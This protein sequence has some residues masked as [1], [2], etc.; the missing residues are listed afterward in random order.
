[1]INLHNLAARIRDDHPGIA[2]PGELSALVLAEIDPRDYADALSITLRSYVRHVMTEPRRRSV[3]QPVRERETA[4]QRPPGWSA[5]SQGIRDGWRAHLND[6]YSVAGTWKFLRDLTR[7]DL[8]TVA[9][10]RYD[11]ARANAYEA[12][13]AERLAALME[14]HGAATVA[15]LPDET[16][17]RVLDY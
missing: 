15:D 7:E 14:R 4:P 10:E 1:M 11:L 5:K 13:R 17:A 12:H 3:P 6:T 9:T 2:D 8:K 16:L